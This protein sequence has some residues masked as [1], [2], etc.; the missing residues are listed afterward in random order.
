MGIG[1]Q[2][3]LIPKLI[4]SYAQPI[5]SD[6]STFADSIEDI[7]IRQRGAVNGVFFTFIF[8]FLTGLGYFYSRG[9]FGSVLSWWMS[10]V[11]AWC[12]LTPLL[13]IACIEMIPIVRTHI[14]KYMNMHK[15]AHNKIC[16]FIIACIS[17]VHTF[18]CTN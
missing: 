9:D 8:I 3:A 2:T 12:L 17:I 13:I 15:N 18:V 10:P 4:N 14:Y 1:T 5:D 6:I 11:F 16:I 7:L